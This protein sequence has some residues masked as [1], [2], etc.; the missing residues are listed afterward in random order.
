MGYR[1]SK[2]YGFNYLLIYILSITLLWYAS[3]FTPY[4]WGWDN[5]LEYYISNQVIQNH[6]WI[7]SLANNINSMLSIVI[8]AP[9]F[10]F[11]C[12]LN[13]VWVYKIIYAALFAFVP[14][15]IYRVF[16]IQTNER[17][18]LFASFFFIFEA[19]FYN[20]LLTLGR[21]EI[22]EIF[23]ALFLLALVHKK[24]N[25][26]ERIMLLIIF[27]FSIVVSHY[28]TA[29]L[30]IFV[31]LIAMGISKFLDSVFF[32]KYYDYLASKFKFI[33]QISSIASD[34][35]SR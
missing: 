30:I 22:A 9:I 29:Y 14:V 26:P 16:E 15:I 3:L 21:Q 19:N 12:N 23:V 32:Q 10:S 7:P 18:A 33:K 25:Y 28:G 8:L 31:L 35:L 13:S 11:F 17:I 27:G 24:I 5:F 6:L 2:S 1:E 34:N 20:S 4:I